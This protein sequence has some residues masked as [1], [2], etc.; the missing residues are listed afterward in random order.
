MVSA[1][2]RAARASRPRR[3]SA[4]ATPWRTA[5]SRVAAR[6]GRHAA[7]RPR[8]RSP[9]CCAR[10]RRGARRRDRAGPPR[11]RAPTRCCSRPP[12]AIEPSFGPGSCER[13]VAA[14]RAAGVACAGRARCRALALDVDTAGRPG[15]AGGD[16]RG[17]GA[18]RRPSTRGA[19]RQLDRC[20]RGAG[21]GA[22]LST[23]SAP[24]RSRRCPTIRAGDDLAAL[25]AAAAPA[26]LARRRRDRGR[27]QGRVEGRGALRRLADVEPGERARELAA[28][29]GKDPRLVQVVLD[30][31]AELLR[32]DERRA[33]LRDPPRL[34]VRERGRGPVERRRCRRGRAAA[35]GS[36]RLGAAAAGG[37][38]AARGVRP[39]VVVSDS[40]GRAWRL[41]QTD[42]AIGAAGLVPLDDWG[43]R[44]D[45]VRPRAARDRDRGGGRGRRRR[46]PRARKDS[47]E[48]AVL[49]ARARA[50]R[51]RR[52]RARRGGTAARARA[53]PVPL[54]ASR[55]AR[56]RPRP[57]GRARSRG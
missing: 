8:A 44:P 7:A 4:S 51:D 45:G 30:E 11:R 31:S 55:P 13:H 53:G 3:R 33:D 21:R 40:F 1:R 18:A 32:A 50:L 24:A 28:E 20:R 42:V 26:E 14:A 52:R 39:A 17:R 36:G 2:H 25:I 56:R 46:R 23:V 5:S 10:S 16:A 43:G 47:R 29:H 22:R 35:G 15:R 37:I 38:A 41:G 9:A 57:A 12:D 19:L 27:A 6:A 34:R 54:G 49:R 48:P